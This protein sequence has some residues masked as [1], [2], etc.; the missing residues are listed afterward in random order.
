MDA[1]ADPANSKGTT[2][3]GRPPVDRPPLTDAE[4]SATVVAVTT[5][6]GDPTRRQIYL[7]GR[8]RPDRHGWDRIAL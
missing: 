7:F 6:F 4:F 8:D 5:A 3:T 1:L 2:D